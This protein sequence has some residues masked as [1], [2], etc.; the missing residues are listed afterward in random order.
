[1]LSVFH[2][3]VSVKTRRACTQP[4]AAR[5]AIRS[6]SARPV[7]K[8]AKEW[9]R[10]QDWWLRSGVV[11]LSQQ[12]ARNQSSLQCRD[13]ASPNYKLTTELSSKRKWCV[14]MNL[15][16][17]LSSSRGRFWEQALAPPGTKRNVT[18]KRSNR[19][20]RATGRWAKCPGYLLRNNSGYCCQ[21]QISSRS[22]RT[23]SSKGTDC[24]TWFFSHSP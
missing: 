19:W 13:T 18:E 6:T 20:K 16:I 11:Q 2:K 4:R 8:W 9:W 7:E 3:K 24:T 14:F 1:M 21:Y 5:A 10:E 22:T 12:R 23:S 15:W 17:D